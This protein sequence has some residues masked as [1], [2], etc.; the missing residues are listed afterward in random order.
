MGKGLLNEKGTNDDDE[1][2]EQMSEEE[3]KQRTLS[4]R[5]DNARKQPSKSHQKSKN[6]QTRKSKKEKSSEYE[7]GDYL[8]WTVDQNTHLIVIGSHAN[9]DNKVSSNLGKVTR[10]INK[11]EENI[12][13]V[14]TTKHSVHLSFL[15][16][17]NSTI[18][19]N[20]KDFILKLQKDKNKKAPFAARLYYIASHPVELI[21][22]L[23]RAHSNPNDWIFFASSGTESTMIAALHE[24]RNC[25]S[26]END[27]FNFSGS[28]DKV[29]Y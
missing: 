29:H 4:K 8:N 25:I 21:E 28:P 24:E 5:E 1:F 6:Q 15:K 18:L 22:N 14:E 7:A 20:Q 16:F 9:G 3:E 26:M 23:V 11:Q 2:E 12:L 13:R 19:Q 17:K 27:H 10:I